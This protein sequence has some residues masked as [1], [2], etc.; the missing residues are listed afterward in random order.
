MADPPCLFGPNH[1]WASVQAHIRV[2]SAAPKSWPQHGQY[3]TRCGVVLSDP[4]PLGGP[5]KPIEILRDDR[6]V[7][8]T[9]PGHQRS[10][11]PWRL[12]KDGPAPS[13]SPLR[14]VKGGPTGAARLKKIAIIEERDGPQC[15]YC[16]CDFDGE[17]RQ[18][19]EH[20][21]SRSQGGTNAIEN[22]VL[23]CWPC[24]NRKGEGPE[25]QFLKSAWL[26]ARRVA[27][28]T[29]REETG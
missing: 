11:K 28:A 8:P 9:V 21:K 10:A 3:C 15:F 24:N 4:G 25:A 2:H 26:Q 7:Y 18:T 17:N 20:R 13:A 14:V 23:A 16:R 5:T 22:L 27:I 19:I 29:E 6:R 12:T 1:S